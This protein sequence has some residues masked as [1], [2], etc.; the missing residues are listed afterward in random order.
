MVLTS[1]RRRY[2]SLSS[3]TK[4]YIK[5]S[6]GEI[7]ETV[8]KLTQGKSSILRGFVKGEDGSAVSDACV[9]LY[10]TLGKS[11]TDEYTLKEAALTDS[12]GHFILGPIE[13]SVLYAVYI[14]KND[15]KKRELELKSRNRSISEL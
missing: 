1:Y 13:P 6:E 3:S 4:F 12:D 7:I 2:F 15:L 5:P 14:Y 10:D 8:V 9:L 11:N